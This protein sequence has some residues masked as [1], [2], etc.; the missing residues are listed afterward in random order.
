MIAVVPALDEEAAIGAVVQALRRVVADEV[1][2]VDGGSR[3]ATAERARAA[4]A[5]VVGET[6]RGYGRACLTG[7]AHASDATVLLFCDGDGSDVIEQATRLT[8]PILDGHAD[9]VIGSRIRGRRQPGSMRIHQLA[10]NVMVAWLLRVR[11]HA[12]VTDVGPFRAIRASI[13]PTLELRE[14]TY[15]LPTEMIAR[16][17]QRGYRVTEVPVDYRARGGG[18]SK[19]SSSLRGSLLAGYH[20]LRVAW[21]AGTTRSEGEDML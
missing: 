20:M 5:R 9:L 6:R 1:I 3:D 13:L 11:H 19:V 21:A 2:V 4:G 10:G 15:G 17:A 8:Q 12:R 7:A 14:M 18:R 16:A